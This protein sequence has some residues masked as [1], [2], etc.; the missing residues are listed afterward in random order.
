MAARQAI[1]TPRR[2][3]NVLQHM[4]GYFKQALDRDSLQ[5]TFIRRLHH[6][7]LERGDGPRNLLAR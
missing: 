2:Q 6:V 4:L 5:H 7:L 3:T 1:A